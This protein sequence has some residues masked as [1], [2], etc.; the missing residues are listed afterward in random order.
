VV[1]DLLDHLG[2]EVLLEQLGAGETGGVDIVV[3]GMG[4]GV[5]RGA[6]VAAGVATGGTCL[7]DGLAGSRDRRGIGGR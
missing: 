4:L 1:L 6:G 3:V 7:L 2:A 5:G